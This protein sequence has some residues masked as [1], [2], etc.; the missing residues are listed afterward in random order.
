MLKDIVVSS[1]HDARLRR[2]LRAR[3]GLPRPADRARGAKRPRASRATRST[4]RVRAAAATT[5]HK[6]VERQAAHFQRLRRP[7]RLGEP[8]PD[9]RP[10][11]RGRHPR[12]P[13]PNRRPTA[14][15]STA[16]KPVPLVH[17]LPH[18]AGRGRAGVPD[19]TSPAIY[20][21][22]PVVD[23]AA[24]LAACGVPDGDPTAMADQPADLDHHAVDAAGEP[25][26]S[27]NPE[28]DLRR[29]C[30]SAASR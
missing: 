29:W 16:S 19:Q 21:R 10:P 23:R 7:R 30:T 15:L 27:L 13:R 8:L 4:P 11:R 5:R 6:W 20:V 28:L 3:L 9:P 12:R 2:A 25:G 18:R 24:A 17:G 14:H 26:A 22:F 1:L